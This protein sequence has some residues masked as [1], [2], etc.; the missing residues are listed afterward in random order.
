MGISPALSVLVMAF[1]VV[2]MPPIL[3]DD[4]RNQA[5]R[6]EVI[7]TRIRFLDQHLLLPQTRLLLG[8]LDLLHS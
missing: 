2:T 4:P 5:G 8:Y 7:A 3:E 6:M 1:V